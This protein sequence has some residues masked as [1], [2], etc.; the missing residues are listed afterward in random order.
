MPKGSE[1]CDDPGTFAVFAVVAANYQPTI[2]RFAAGILGRRR[3]ANTQN[4]G[5]ARCSPL[6]SAVSGNIS[7]SFD[8]ILM[9]TTISNLKL[10]V[11]LIHAVFAS[12]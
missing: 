10:L 3:S 2:P 12:I 8:G 4:S 1:Q 7:A 9:A 5:R 11:N 6:F